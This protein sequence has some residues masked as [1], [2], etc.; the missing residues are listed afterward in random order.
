[1]R[2]A[3]GPVL[4]CLVIAA[5]LYASGGVLD[6]L[7]LDGARVRVALLPPWESAVGLLL[8]A[9][10][11]VALSARLAPRSGT[12]ERRRF[13]DVLWPLAGSAVLL[14]PFLPLVADWWPVLQILAGPLRWVVWLV[15]AM[16]AIWAWRQQP[17]D[18]P[19]R[20]VSRWIPRR[21]NAQAVLIGIAT[22]IVSGA[23]ASQLTGTVLYPAGDEP[24]YLIIAQSLWRD[25][26]L[27]IEN[28]H[29]QGDYW[30]YF[31]QELE[32]HYL[33]RG[34]DGEIYSI[35]PVGLP[36]LMA[37][38][39]AAGGYRGVVIALIAMAAIA[40]ALAWRWIADTVGSPE[41]ATFGWAAVAVSTPFVFNTF[42]VY[43]EIAAA[44]AV[45]I[46]V[47]TRNPWVLGIAS[48]CLPWLSTKYAPMSAALLATGLISGSGPGTWRL[49]PI[50]WIVGAA[51]PYAALLAAWF[52][53][54]YVIWGSP[55]PQAPYGGMVQ[56]SPWNLGFGAPGLLFD[57]EY[58]LLPYAP[59]YALAATGLWALWRRGG[60]HR[61]LAIR[62]GLV[63]LALLG[64]VGAFRIWWGGAA[65][66][67]RPLASGLLLL[68]LPIGVAYAEASP[69]TARRAAQYL[70]LWIGVGI[71]VQ[72]CLAQDGFLLSNGRDGSSALL[73]WWLPR[74]PTWSLVPTFIYHE[75]G[76]ATVQSLI[77]IAVA[78]MCAAALRRM[79]ARGPGA[80]ALATCAIFA[81]GL[82]AAA[83]LFRLVPAEPPQPAVN[84][85]ARARI[86]ALDSFDRRARPAAVVYN[87][88]SKTSAEDLMSRVTLEV[89]PGLRP[90]PQ[91]LRVIHNGRFSLPAGRY[92][93]NVAFADSER[94]GP[95]D[96][97]LQLGRTG[98]PLSTWTVDPGHGPWTVD[99]TLPADVGFVGFRGLR[100]IERAV[101]E[102]TITPLAVTDESQRP[103]LPPVLGASWHGETLVLFHD[104]WTV[105]EPD[106]FWIHGQRPTQ[107]TFAAADDKPVAPTVHIRSE[108]I[109]NRVTLRAPGW[110]RA[111]DLKP[112]ETELVELPPP[113]RGVITVIVE[114]E[115]GFV[116]ADK[117]PASHDRRLLGVWVEVR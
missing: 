16:L 111:M 9:A 19:S 92:R 25:G 112:G 22:A 13:P 61:A 58:G 29:D 115:S 60:E 76:P 97:S 55:W 47:T 49:A 18:A 2:R 11:A 24:H 113:S 116:P 52:T 110:E 46:G 84:L 15:V 79:P 103:R 100:E 3:A 44:L 51:I 27:K 109:P 12:L 83:L 14:L 4:V 64:T 95:H 99:F 56:T 71:A 73:E 6:E 77:W 53:F 37:P 65:S 31:E 108:R 35:H 30:E 88:L 40:A 67:S 63:F 94:I 72:M 50:R 39:Y 62:V 98:P 1:M 66:P 43:P 32:P 91:P 54:F 117:D 17:V 114:T 89:T 86:T 38:V 75:A 106:G 107:L 68:A 45:M 82:I 101:R 104:D 78:G 21:R 70:L 26:D 36:I 28:N 74:W 42:S 7:V 23:A 87:P 10:V 41:A 34:V 102:I 8:A 85:S 48:G 96:L 81:S 90:Q 5:A 33:T 57:Q 93:A 59:A 69:G 20:P 105:S 80:A